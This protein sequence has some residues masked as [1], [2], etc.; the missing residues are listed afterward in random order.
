MFTTPLQA[1][2]VRVGEWALS[3]RL[4]WQDSDGKVSSTIVV[5]AHFVTDYASVPKC[6]RDLLVDADESKRPFVLH[7]WLYCSNKRGSMTRAE[8]DALLR[9]AM[10]EDGHGKLKALTYYTGVRVGGWMYWQKKAQAGLT[11]DDFLL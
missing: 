4:V 6:L 7:D 2:L 10:V 1:V 8:A 11:E 9:K 3:H 5:P